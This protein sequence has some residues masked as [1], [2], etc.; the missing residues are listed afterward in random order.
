MKLA[1]HDQITRQAVKEFVAEFQ[2]DSARQLTYTRYDPE[3]G[4]IE[5]GPE[6]YAVLRDIFDVLTLGHWSN[7]AQQ[8]HFMRRFDGQSPFQAYQDGC[9]WI[10]SNSLEFAQAV[11]KGNG[12]YNLAPLGYACHCL[13]DSFAHGHCSR[14]DAAS[15]TRPGAITHVKMYAGDEK[16]NHSH[17]DETWKNPTTGKLS[18]VGDPGHDDDKRYGELAKNA[19]KALLYVIFHEA[20]VAR[21]AK[22]TVN[23]L[24]RFPAFQ[25][26]WL[27]ASPLLRRERNKAY[28][29]I[30]K[31]YSGFVWGDTNHAV[32]FDEAGLAGAIYSDLQA[33]TT[34]VYKTFWRLNEYHTVDADD[35]AEIYVDKLRGRNATPSTLRAVAADSRLKNLLIKVLDEG[36]TTDNEYA[37][38][39]FLKELK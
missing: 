33:D 9:N 36:W 31:Y 28:D 29:L 25:N 15:D 39:D 32:N 35:V 22:S 27:A 2:H 26:K 23:A 19:V 10:L 3:L 38:I 7:F 37:C 24:S 12:S 6:H 17:H 20:Y 1:G 8:H 5:Y 14:E 34:E 21:N 11:A 30:D 13:E 4:P 18:K 16:E